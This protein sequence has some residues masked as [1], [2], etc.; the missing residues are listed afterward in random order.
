MKNKPE[1]CVLLRFSEIIFYDGGTL[2]LPSKRKKMRLHSAEKSWKINPIIWSIKNFSEFK[3]WDGDT[4]ILPSNRKNN[5]V[6]YS[7]EKIK[8]NKLHFCILLQFHEISIMSCRRFDLA[9]KLEKYLRH[10]FVLKKPWKINPIF[11]SF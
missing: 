4:L 7:A 2:I 11:V 10:R 9:V 5:C 3:C 1:F 8:K 6:T